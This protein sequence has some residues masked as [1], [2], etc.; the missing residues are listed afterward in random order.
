MTLNELGASLDATKLTP[1][2]SWSLLDAGS[3][4]ITE[5]IPATGAASWFISY[6]GGAAGALDDNLFYSSATGV[7]SPP[8]R[9]STADPATTLT[10]PGIVVVANGTPSRLFGNYCV[11]GNSNGLTLGF[12]SNQNGANNLAATEGTATPWRSLFT[13]VSLFNAIGAYA[14][15]SA[16]F[17]NPA[18]PTT[19]GKLSGNTAAYNNFRNWILGANSA[20]NTDAGARYMLSA[21]LA[22][23]ILNVNVGAGGNKL[24]ASLTIP[25]YGG[26][27]QGLIEEAKAALANPTLKGNFTTSREY[28]LYLK[29]FL[30]A[31]NNNRA[32]IIP[33][34]A[35]GATLIS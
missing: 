31:L 26:T 5:G 10:I 19:I 28:Q 2:A 14:I 30:D 9:L 33:T 15:P 16:T 11:T 20:S 4:S 29:N 13:G 24:D 25:A 12:W 22:A 27:I 1:N 7:L 6:K 35:C 17:S 34:N 23:V 18:W 32:Q 3:Y 21:Q 8:A